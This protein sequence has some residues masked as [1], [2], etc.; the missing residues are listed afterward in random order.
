MCWDR[1]VSTCYCNGTIPCA[2]DPVQVSQCDGVL[3]VNCSPD[4]VEAV[5]DPSNCVVYHLCVFGTDIATF[6]CANGKSFFRIHFSNSI[7]LS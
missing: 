3:V 7:K 5:G 4:V 6:S 1:S 2:Y